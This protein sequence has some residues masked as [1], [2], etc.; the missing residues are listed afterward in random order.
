MIKVC[1][2]MSTYNGE[3]FLVEQIES[4]L[5]QKDV[6]VDLVVR[7]DGSTDK[8]LEILNEYKKQKRLTILENNCN[9]GPACSFMELLYNSGDYDYYAF[10]DQDDIWL[11]DKLIKAISRLDE[12]YLTPALYCSNQWIY[13]EGKVR[14]LRYKND[15]NHGLIEAICGN[16][17]SGCTM[18]FNGKLACVLK[19]ENNRPSSKLL[20]I[21]MHDTWV[22]AVA[23][24]VGTVFYDKESYIYYRI[25]QNNAVGIKNKRVSEFLKKHFVYRRNFGRSKLA[26]ELLKINYFDDCNSEKKDIVEA[27]AFRKGL[28]RTDILRHCNENPAFFIFKTI[29]RWV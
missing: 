26:K 25:H 12:Y 3:K 14:H 5:K 8:T 11:E 19:D 18:V 7:D 27:F 2:L 22:I 6:K 20:N 29:L 17:F 13:A 23:E 9:I 16:K 21:R 24:Y 15:I 4:I 1:V 28:I 10:S